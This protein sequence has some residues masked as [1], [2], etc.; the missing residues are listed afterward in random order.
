MA[1]KN[2]KRKTTHTTTTKNI[3]KIQNKN[4]QLPHPRPWGP[5]SALILRSHLQII[6]AQGEF[7]KKKK[8]HGRKE[9]SS[10]IPREN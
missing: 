10:K 6:A 8:W 3:Q 7:S 4:N 2:R 9:N 5:S 1:N